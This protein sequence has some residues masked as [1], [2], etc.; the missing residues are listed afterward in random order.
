M[1]FGGGVVAR[2]RAVMGLDTKEFEAGIDKSGRKAKDFQ[3]VIQGVGSALGVAFSVG[4]VIALGK[5]MMDWAG[6]ISDAAGNVGI[7]TETMAAQNAVFAENGLGVDELSKMYAK[8]E[9]DVFSAATGGKKLDSIYERL[10]F[11]LQDLAAMSPD[12]RLIAV[13]KAALESA[14]ATGALAEVF[15]SKLGPKARLALEGIVAGYADVSAATGKAIDDI[16]AAGDRI[17]GFYEKAKQLGT[18]YFAWWIGQWG[19][20]NDVIASVLSGGNPVKNFK[21][22]RGERARR[23]SRP[24]EQRRAVM[25]KERQDLMNA[26]AKT[27]TEQASTQ[28]AAERDAQFKEGTKSWEAW[29]K[30]NDDVWRKKVAVW[31][32]QKAE[33]AR[34]RDQ[35]ADQEK[36]HEERLISIRENTR[37]QGVNPDN[38]ARVGL[39]AGGE[40]AGLA[41]LDRQVNVQIESAKAVRENTVAVKEL[42]D[43]LA[44]VGKTGGSAD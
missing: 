17:A 40:R 16:D 12:E 20:A 7:L 10:G 39:F 42:K 36:R 32:R 14:N 33:R 21:E 35:I 44:L 19:L 24:G 8:M 41:A 23:E 34:I 29:E 15:G 18:S 6:K 25:E 3:G 37:G 31:D 1:S 9:T 30:A 22:F 28:A 27:A 4:G 26:A 38:M 43:Q 5:T 13:A 11:T 2:L